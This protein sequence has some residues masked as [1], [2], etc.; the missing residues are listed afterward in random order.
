MRTVGQIPLE[1]D[2]HHVGIITSLSATVVINSVT[3]ACFAHCVG[4][5]IDS[6]LMLLWYSAFPVKS[7]FMPAVMILTKMIIKSIIAK[8]FLTS[9]LPANQRKVLYSY[10]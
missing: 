3:R 6:S 9:A 5:P 4:E 2:L 1:E 7:G 8:I 10:W